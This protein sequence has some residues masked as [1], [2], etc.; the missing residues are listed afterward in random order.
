MPFGGPAALPYDQ[1]PTAERE[2]AHSIV[3]DKPSEEA[4]PEPESESTSEIGSGSGTGASSSIPD[5][6]WEKFVRDS[7]R[8]IRA[9]SAPKEPSARAR[10]VTERLRQRDEEA[11]RQDSKKRRWR[12]KSG[13]KA[14]AGQP[15]QPEGWR[16]G[17]A[18]QEMEGRT[19]RRRRWW[20][21]VGVP[22][23]VALA[24]VAIKPSL[25]PGD[26]FGTGEQAA[27]T[28]PQLP[29]ETAA[30]TAPPSSAAPDTP[31]LERPFAGS[32]A[33]RWA[34]GAA[35]IVLPKATPSGVFSASQVERALQQSKTLLIDANLSPGTLR[36]QRPEAAL[37][38]LDPRQP[39][40]LSHLDASLRAPDEKHDPLALF[41]RFDPDEARLVGDVVKTRGRMTFRTANRG[42]LVVHADYTFV[43]P[44]VRPGTSEVT[45]TIVRRVVDLELPNP[46][47]FQI[48]PG[49][50]SLLRY[51]E[52]ASNSACQIYDGYLHPQFDSQQ[53]TGAPPTG[54][55]TDPYDRS[56]DLDQ[57]RSKACGTASR[58]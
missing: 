20:G 24:V 36:G 10:L 46:A 41:S 27:D 40:L 23:A 5:D 55:T 25:I 14:A 58:T 33:Q 7:E 19:A 49:K 51:D 35:G 26:P 15:L 53:P 38:V 29:P 21:I 11:A 9:S 52:D 32:P 6:V 18:W 3:A 54:P 57:D 37:G 47:H 12:G 28:A 13:D 31:T 39:D 56:K 42:S 8:D 4:R 22:L 16:T 45:R 48:T 43:Y 1:P 30:P 34:D 50:L 2:K 44:L 17:P